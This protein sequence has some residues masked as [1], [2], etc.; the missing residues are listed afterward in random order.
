[1]GSILGE[2]AAGS[3]GWPSACPR[4]VL[5]ALGIGVC[6]S[7]EAGPIQF[8]QPLGIRSTPD[9]REVV[10]ADLDGDGCVDV[11]GIQGGANGVV[12]IRGTCSDNPASATTFALASQP[13][14]LAGADL[15]H[16]GDTDLVVGGM[17]ALRDSVVFLNNDGAAAFNQFPG[18]AL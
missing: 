2:L 15:D 7:V 13:Q 11:A 8:Q 4:A 14:C 1:M 5:L 6:A 3:G 10:L 12:L 16:D 9:I 18:P 17:G